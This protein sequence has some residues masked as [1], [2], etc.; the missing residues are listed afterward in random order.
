MT[1]RLLLTAPEKGH[2]V[3]SLSRT[4]HSVPIHFTAVLSVMYPGLI[5]HDDSILCVTLF[6]LLSQH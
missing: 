3:M 4:A 1:T 6:C 5:Q 2:G